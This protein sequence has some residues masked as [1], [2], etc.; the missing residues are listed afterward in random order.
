MET[1]FYVQVCSSGVISLSTQYLHTNNQ[2]TYVNE[3]DIVGIVLYIHVFLI[4]HLL[5]DISSFL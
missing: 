2:T 4:S 1:K 3:S 5:N